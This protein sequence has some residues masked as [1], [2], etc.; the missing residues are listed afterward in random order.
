VETENQQ[1]RLPQRVRRGRRIEFVGV[2]CGAGAPDPGCGDAPETLRRDGIAEVLTARGIPALWNET[3]SP[4]LAAATDSCAVVASICE[5]LARRV[6]EIVSR[7]ALPVVL[8]GDHSCAIGTWKG[9]ARAVAPRGP[10]GL[11]WIDAHMDAHTPHTTPS[12]KPHGMPLACLLGHGAPALVNIGDGAR[13]DPKHV[14]L[15][16][17]RSFEAGEAGLLRR[18]GV[19]VMCMPEI[20]RRGLPAVMHEALAIAAA[21]N[22]GFGVT[23]DLDVLDPRDA[24]GVGSPVPGGLRAR[25]LL[26]V[27]AEVGRCSALSG[28]E[29]V[30]FNP[31]LDRDRKTAALVPELLGALLAPVRAA[32]PDPGCARAK[33]SV[34]A[35]NRRL[36]PAA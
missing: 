27:L 33:R 11:I 9:L 2:A 5:R 3:L 1:H 6:P 35:C 36:R 17:V 22:A 24:P 18:L 21:G 16:G 13:L 7:G 14:C 8:G 29:I 23:L 12:G 4:A 30:E 31:H 19:R 10:P 28:I 26:P 20:R 32:R 25:E 34:D 15:I